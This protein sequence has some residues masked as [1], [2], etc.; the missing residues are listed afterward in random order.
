MSWTIPDGLRTRAQG[1][2]A[3]VAWLDSV[4]GTSGVAGIAERV[5]AAWDLK[6][7]GDVMAGFLSLVRPVRDRAGRALVLKLYGPVPGVAGEPDFLRTVAGPGVVELV[8][9]DPGAGALLLE[10]LDPGRTL[11]GLPDVDEAC[12]VIGSLVGQICAHPS[13]AGM[14]SVA[15]E[16]DRLH[17]SISSM[18]DRTPEVLPRALA[19]RAL[20]TLA[21]LSPPLRAA[22][23]PLPIVHGDLHF[24]NVLHTRPGG[25]DRWVA[26]DPL[27]SA[28]YPEWEVTASLRNRWPDAVAT[29]DPERALRRR[30]DIIGEAA[31]LDRSLAVA[32]A[33][34]VAVDNLLWLSRDAAQQHPIV[35][36][37]VPPYQIVATWTA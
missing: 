17:A 35:Q 27:P 36:G 7:D 4:A 10:R 33:Q 34:A 12:G 2:P 16:L 13:P 11:D 14:R 31:G 9:D 29:G 21:A 24:E 20:D 25:P 26:I 30:V 22:A 6:P 18:L 5:S 8:R 15:D 3:K 1:D 32:I 28:G 37:F 23:A 19:D